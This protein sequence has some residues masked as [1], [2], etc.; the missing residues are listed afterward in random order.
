MGVKKFTF[1]NKKNFRK[2]VCIHKGGVDRRL[3]MWCRGERLKVVRILCGG[4]ILIFQNQNQ[5]DQFND[6]L[7]LM[8]IIRS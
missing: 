3:I 2:F 1:F 4:N 6:V 7:R 8:Y 5:T